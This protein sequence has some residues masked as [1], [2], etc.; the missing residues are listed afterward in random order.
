MSITPTFTQVTVAITD[1][2]SIIVVP[3]M[4]NQLSITGEAIIRCQVEPGSLVLIAIPGNNQLNG[5]YVAGNRECGMLRVYR[6][7]AFNELMTGNLYFDCCSRG[8]Y[9]VT[10]TTTTGAVIYLLVPRIPCD[11][12]SRHVDIPVEPCHKRKHK[13]HCKHH[14]G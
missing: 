5:L 2:A 9:Q 14:C 11:C 13:K 6:T 8:L 4:T 3:N 10:M 7:I 1:L 12:D